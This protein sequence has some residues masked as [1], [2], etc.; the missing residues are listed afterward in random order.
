MSFDPHGHQDPLTN[1][2]G[3]GERADSASRSRA[4]A[5]ARERVKLPAVFLIVVGVLNLLVALFYAGVTIFIAV[6]PA[7]KMHEMQIDTYETL[8]KS[9]PFAKEM[10]AAMRKQ[11]PEDQKVKSVATNSITSA[12]LLVAAL[13]VIFG[14]MRMLQMRSYGMCIL[15]SIVTSIPCIS[16]TCCCGVG[17]IVGVWSIIVLLDETV[18]GFFR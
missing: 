5:E 6:Q 11:D 7:D 12:V 8:G 15:A 1:P 2:P 17:A 13:V 10:A 18:R 14:G 16:P 3:L 9:Y 4:E